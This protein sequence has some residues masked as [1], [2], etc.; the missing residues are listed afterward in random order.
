M[1]ISVSVRRLLGTALAAALLLALLAGCGG[2]P[3]LPNPF[4]TPTPRPT[5]TA[6]PTATPS[7]QSQTP[8]SQQATPT[9]STVELVWWTPVWFSP[10]SND[11]AGEFL[12]QR[13]AAFEEAHPDIR[14]RVLV[15]PP[16]GKGGIKDYLLGAYKVAPAL[17]PDLV[18][19]D[20]TDMVSFAPLGIFQPLSGLTDEMFAPSF[21]PVAIEAGTVQEQW[22][23]VQFEANFYHV[24]YRQEKGGTPPPS[25]WEALLNSDISYWTYIFD[26]TDEASDVVL[27]QYM[28]SGGALPRK[29]AVPMDEQALL[30]VFNYYDQAY[31]RGVIPEASV[32]AEGEE[33][34]WTALLNEKAP[35][36]DA[37]A[38]RYAREGLQN[39]ELAIAPIPTWDG[40]PRALA[41]GWGMGITATDPRRQQAAAALLQW[42]LSPDT[43]GTWT[44]LGGYIPTRMD[45]LRSWNAPSQYIGLIDELLQ[46]AE[47][48]PS[49][50]ALASLRHA[51]AVGLQS[52]LVD[53]EAPETGVRKAMDVY[54]P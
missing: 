33:D 9:P 23:A 36:A 48:Y 31:R 2:E 54:T 18:A 46:A 45:A 24:V 4:A 53:G 8:A 37:N 6:T 41:R 35:M 17:L 43:L 34:L 20:M 1:G 32:T 51:L 7:T 21:Y 50:A 16:Y 30:N 13:L 39:A 49:H 47:P 11:P 28:A 12:G 40:K 14:V 44:Q 42:L 5:A 3:R 26:T 15:K 29:E 10:Q 27:L 38:R 25:T 19:F 52:I 22:L